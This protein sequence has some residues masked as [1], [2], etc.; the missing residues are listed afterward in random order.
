M[1]KL[2]GGFNTK[3]PRL[4]RIP[5]FD[6]RSKNFRVRELIATPTPRSYT[7]S[8]P[9]WLDQGREGACVGFSVSHEAAARPVEVQGITDATA[10]ALYKRAQLLDEWPGEDYAGTSILAGV[11]AAQE[12]AWYTEYR[13]AFSVEELAL[14][15]GYKG[16]AI[17]GV[18]WYN[19]MYNPNANGQIWPTGNLVG[20]H[21]ILVR[22][23]SKKYKMFLLRNSWGKW[24]GKEGDCY[25]SYQDMMVLLRQDGEACIPIVR[26]K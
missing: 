19:D 9:I 23:Y 21:A 26:R 22:G 25:L 13:W 8:C 11:K 18:N 14:A 17:I 4:D 15:V 3:D 10:Q 12:R 7:W 1:I 2:K 16:P 5:Q 24:W 6:E 20:G